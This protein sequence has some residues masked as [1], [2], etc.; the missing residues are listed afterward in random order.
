MKL[1]A[2][3][4]CLNEARTLPRTLAELPRRVAGFDEVEWLV[5]DDGSTDS[6]V[7]VARAHRVD[8]IVRL[9]N[10]ADIGRLVAPILAG[11]ADMVVGDRGVRSLE[12]WPRVG[13]S[14][15]ADAVR[16]LRGLGSWAVL[17]GAG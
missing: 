1:I 16:E 12:H 8:H 17:A 11:E 2:Q 3:I 14:E 7:D 13:A 6:T 5:I 15:H 10:A 4:P 9:T